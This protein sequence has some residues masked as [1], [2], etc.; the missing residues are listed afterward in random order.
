MGRRNCPGG[1]G[2]AR[3]ERPL[4]LANALARGGHDGGT[5][6][7]FLAGGEVLFASTGKW[8]HPLFELEAFLRAREID[9]SQ[10]EIRDKVI[11]RGAAFLIVRMGIRK[12]HA[13]M[14]S[15]LG[16][17]VLDRAD[18]EYGWDTLV[19][20]IA[21]RTEGILRAVTDAEEAYRIL[22]ELRQKAAL[23]R[24]P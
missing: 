12:A 2:T 15:L 14:L 1:D 10:G 7:E 11:G 5:S 22:A 21:C 17:D 18:V 19:E 9:A 8:L 24:R 16:K 13:G 4:T 6:L 20:E 3:G 23:D